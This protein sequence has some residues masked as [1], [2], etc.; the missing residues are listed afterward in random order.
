[1]QPR[2]L[3]FDWFVKCQR[4]FGLETFAISIPFLPPGVVINDPEILEYVLK[5]QTTITKGEF[6][7]KRSW[8]LFGRCRR[9]ILTEYIADRRPRAWYPQHRWRDVEDTAK[10]RVEVLHWFEPGYRGR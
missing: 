2:H 1:M 9:M 7:R 4:I 6:F 8:D 5:N 10:S 3:L